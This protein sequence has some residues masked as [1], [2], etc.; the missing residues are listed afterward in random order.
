MN[1][2]F[3]KVKEAPEVGQYKETAIDHEKRNA[4]IRILQ[5]GPI[6]VESRVE[7]AGIG[8]KNG[9][10]AGLYEVSKAALKKLQAKYYVVTDF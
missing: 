3:T 6:M 7:L 2:T 8:I 1:V 5:V 9:K 10:R 4:D